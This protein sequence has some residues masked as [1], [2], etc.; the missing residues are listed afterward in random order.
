[1]TVI[2]R[3]SVWAKLLSPS[4]VNTSAPLSVATVWKAM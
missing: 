1:V 2:V 3:V 4:Q